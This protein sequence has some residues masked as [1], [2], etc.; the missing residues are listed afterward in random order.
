[1][2]HEIIYSALSNYA[3]L[4]ALVPADRIRPA[5]GGHAQQG[6]KPYIIYQRVGNTPEWTLTGDGG[7]DNDR[8]QIDVYGLTPIEVSSIEV[9]VR[10]AMETATNF[11]IGRV[12]SG[13]TYEPETNLHRVLLDF[14]VWL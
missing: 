7:R 10:L 4:T 1:M 3:G 14:S 9:Q 11:Q 13:N 5:T 12:F 2:S 8:Y 6:E